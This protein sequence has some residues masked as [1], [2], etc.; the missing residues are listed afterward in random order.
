MSD[1]RTR[2]LCANDSDLFFSS[3]RADITRAKEI[4]MSCPVRAQ[5]A[6]FAEAARPMFGVWAGVDRSNPSERRPSAR[7]RKKAA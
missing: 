6:S 3:E 2:G 1:W 7:R 5:C 4:C